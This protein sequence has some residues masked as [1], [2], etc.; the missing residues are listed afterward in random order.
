ME[1][2][3]RESEAEN[4]Q[5]LKQNNNK[6]QLNWQQILRPVLLEIPLPS[7]F[8]LSERSVQLLRAYEVLLHSYFSISIEY[9]DRK[10]LIHF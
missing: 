10:G 9:F 1:A 4:R 5:M 7:P 8:S 2:G 3:L 6:K